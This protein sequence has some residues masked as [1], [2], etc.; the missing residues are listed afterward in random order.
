MDYLNE[1][2]DKVVELENALRKT[3]I[4]LKKRLLELLKKFDLTP[5]QFRALIIIKKHSK[6]NMKNIVNKMH[7]KPPTATGI[8][9]RVVKK[10]LVRRYGSKKDRR[11]VNAELTEKGEKLVKEIHKK[12]LSQLKEDIESFDNVEI[13][14]LIN[15]LNKFQSSVSNHGI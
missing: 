10:G 3:S 6:T 13:D 2:D 11:V 5:P 7:R 9:D 14:Q 4:L 15:L 1:F 12:A 8:I